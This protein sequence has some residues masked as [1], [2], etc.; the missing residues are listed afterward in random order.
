MKYLVSVEG[1]IEVEGD[2]ID[3]AFAKALEIFKTIKQ[4]HCVELKLN[5]GVEEI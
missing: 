1:G 5:R 2:T 3:E 4:P